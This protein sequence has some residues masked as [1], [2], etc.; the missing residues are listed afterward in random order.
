[1]V[2]QQTMKILLDAIPEESLRAVL[3]EILTPP[4][5]PSAP[6]STTITPPPPPP[7]PAAARI[8]RPPG[9]GDPAARAAAQRKRD[10]EARRKKRAAARAARAAQHPI[11]KGKD[12][13]EIAE[14]ETVEAVQPPQSDGTPDAARLWAHA[15]KLTPGGKAPWRV[16]ADV[17]DQ[18]RQKAL[19]AF[20]SHTLPPGM[21][22]VQVEKFLELQSAA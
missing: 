12:V 1:M 15:A 4:S 3:L 8:G 6:A 20:R 16:V 14:T 2:S 21:T 22:R 11:G 18:D 7:A 10:T 19:D 9:P 5:S 13:A 17:F